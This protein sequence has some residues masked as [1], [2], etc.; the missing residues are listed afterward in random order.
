MLK[1]VI[2]RT[3]SALL[4]QFRVSKMYTEQTP[5]KPV[6]L[7]FSHVSTPLPDSSVTRC[8][9][10]HLRPTALKFFSGFIFF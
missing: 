3:E 2:H 7:V 8:F 1:E 4:Q 6:Q 10:K 9:G 5:R